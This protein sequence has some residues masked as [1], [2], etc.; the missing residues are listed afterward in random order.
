[1]LRSGVGALFGFAEKCLKAGVAPKKFQIVVVSY[2]VY[3]LVPVLDGFAQVLNGFIPVVSRCCHA[4]EVVPLADGPARGLGQAKLYQAR[5]TF[6]DGAL[7][8]LS[9]ISSNNFFASS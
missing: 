3:V 7:F 8:I 5:E 6:P 4:G 1:M 2:V 9:R